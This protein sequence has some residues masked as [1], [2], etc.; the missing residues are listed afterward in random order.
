[1]TTALPLEWETPAGG[2]T[3]SGRVR[4]RGPLAEADRA[5][6]LH[7]G[8]DGAGPPFDVVPLER[9]DDGSWT[10]EVS[11][12]EGHV[13]LDGA[14]ATEAM[15]WDNNGGAN[16][17]L[18]VDLDPVDAHVHARTRGLESMGFDSLRIALASG[19]MTH[20]LVSWQDNG[21]VDEVAGGVPWLTRLVW[22]GPKG[23]DVDD[24][25]RRLAEGAAGLKVHPSY[26]EYPADTPLLDPFLAVAA[27]RGVPVT[28]H[29]APGPS[30]PDLVARLAE[31][32]PD[33]P[34]VLYH[35][36][37]GF[38][39]GRRRAARHAQRLANLYLETS[40]CSSAEVER[41]LGEVGPERVLFGSDAAVDGPEHFVRRPPNIELTENYNQS[42][43]R[44]A[45]RL[46]EATLRALL[47]ENTR[48]LFRLPAPTVPA[49]EAV[50][51]LFA[52]ALQQADRVVARVPRDRLDSP[53]PCAEWDVR[54]LLGHLL[55]VVRRAERAAQGRPASSVPVVAAVD[56]RG[57]AA[58]QFAAAAA[59][60][61][62]AWAT[63]PPAD[64]PVPWGLLPGPAALSG[65]VLEL[66]AHTHD[67]AV[68]TDQGDPLDPR[69]AEA[70]QRIAER[71]APPALRISGGS[72]AD[73]V[74]APANADAYE[75]LAAFLGRAPVR[76]RSR[77]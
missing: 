20:G 58:A 56:S 12:T 14:V 1:V 25:R 38:P 33:V 10:G 71:L 35:T 17:R 52:A 54:A 5:L 53:T 75:R 15:D 36:F 21:F 57:R 13:L 64:V 28:V 51:E 2:R 24:V 67:L 66:V 6:Q 34:V 47:E 19:G 49:P 62:Q 44:L 68:A 42:L 16:Y 65:F 18:W 74:P 63:A 26:D 23:P 11:G 40:W 4:Y 76:R 32:H 9:D 60:A 43:L 3:P 70:A 77:R 30:D 55:A 69:L 39:E 59:R 46:P 41:L 22:V 7:L 27:E 31:R 37:L 45:Q 61:R 50:D 72:F 48:R 73:P 8:L 29:T